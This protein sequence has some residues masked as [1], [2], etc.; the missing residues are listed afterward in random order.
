MTRYLEISSELAGRVR[1]GDLLPGAELPAIRGY[2]RALGATSSTIVR[3]YR[4]LADAGVITL[5]DRR[6]ERVSTDRPIAAARLLESDRVFRLAGSDAPP[7]NSCSATP[8]LRS[9]RSEPAAAFTVCALWRAAKPTAP[10]S[11]CA[12][13]PL[14]ELGERPALLQ[15]GHRLHPHPL[16][17]PL[18]RGPDPQHLDQRRI[19]P[20]FG[21]VQ[22]DD[23]KL[24]EDIR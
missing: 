17:R 8:A 6:R 24:D 12:T 14:L 3:A 10:R 7:C 1:A 11:T 22:F 15:R 23:R 5:A 21:R 19:I 13:T 18:D 16:R 4:H 20:G 2:A 9:S